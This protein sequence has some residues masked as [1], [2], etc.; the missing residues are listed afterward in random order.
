MRFLDLKLDFVD[1]QIVLEGTQ[2]VLE[3]TQ[4]VLGFLFLQFRILYTCMVNGLEALDEHQFGLGDVAE[5]DGALLE[6]AVGHLLVDEAVDEVADAVFG[7]FGQR[8]RS[9]LDGIGHHED[10]LFAGE[11][12]GAGIGKFLDVD[13]L[14]GML[15]LIFNI[16]VLGDALAVVG[17]DEVL[18]E[19]GQIGALGPVSYTHLTLPTT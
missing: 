9:R 17:E 11:R 6:E 15:I 10:S 8:A 14:V 2:V 18:D 16:E 5:G 4:V 3:G 7:I 13:I 12:I 19:G 1:P